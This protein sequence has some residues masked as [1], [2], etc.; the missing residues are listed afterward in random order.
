[1]DAEALP[2]F[3]LLSPLMVVIGTI[4]LLSPTLPLSRPWARG[5]VL[6]WCGSLL[7]VSRLA[8]IYHGHACEGR[9]VPSLVGGRSAS[10]S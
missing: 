1:M 5:L 6:W 7:L 8:A 2:F 4:Y 9:M 10:R 3:E